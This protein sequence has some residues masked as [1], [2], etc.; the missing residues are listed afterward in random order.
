MDRMARERARFS[1]YSRG[2]ISQVPTRPWSSLESERNLSYVC[3]SREFS[4]FA[5]KCAKWENKLYL[6]VSCGC[7]ESAKRKTNVICDV[8]VNFVGKISTP[9]PTI[10]LHF[11]FFLFL[12]GSAPFPPAF[13]RFIAAREASVSGQSSEESVERTAAA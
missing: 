5:A 11:F 6:V 1:G 4:G 7:L 2:G 13:R 10:Q 8:L 12:A 9:R 3:V